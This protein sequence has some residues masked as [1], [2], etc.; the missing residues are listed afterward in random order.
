[1]KEKHT[2]KETSF[3]LTVAKIIGI[4]EKQ[5]QH[6]ILEDHMYATSSL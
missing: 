3:S 4:R 1:M 6:I 2:Y 5:T